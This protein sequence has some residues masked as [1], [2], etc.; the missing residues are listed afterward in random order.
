M[1]INQKLVTKFAKYTFLKQ[2]T[3]SLNLNMRNSIGIYTTWIG[4]SLE[5]EHEHLNICMETD[6]QAKAD[7]WNIFLKEITNSHQLL[8]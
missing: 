2:T 7:V 5:H 6:L 8:Y 4:S 3:Q 1:R